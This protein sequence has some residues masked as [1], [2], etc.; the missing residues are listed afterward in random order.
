MHD[1][2]LS[3]ILYGFQ[4]AL[5]PENLIYC[6]IGATLGTLIGVLPGLGPITT[7][8]MLM[9]LT[10]K[11][12]VLASLVMLTGIYYGAHHSGS[13]AAIMLNM[14]GEPS[15]IVICLDGH[16]MARQ[17][18]AGAALGIAA[19]GSF[20]AG[21]VG[22]IVIALLSPPL[23]RVS[24]LFGPAEYASMMVMA[25]VT[26][27]ALAA[28]SL[29]TTVAMAVLGVLLGTVGT[30]IT[31]GIERNTFDLDNI[32]DGVSFIAVAVGLFAYSDIIIHLGLP[33]HARRISSK[34][35]R[36]LPTAV[37]MR[38]A[39]KPILRGTAVGASFGVL[40]GTGPLVSSFAS[41]ALEKN[42]ADDKSRFGQGAIE[43]VAGPESANNAATMTHF[44]P[45]LSLGIPAGAANA[46]L[47]G[48]I[49]IHGVTPGP[50]LMTTHPDLFWGVVA[51]MWI[52]NGMLLV[53]NLPMIG[54]WVRALMIPYRILYPAILVFCSIGVYSFNDSYGDVVLAAGFG[55]LGVIFRKLR[56]DPSPLV[57]GLVL[58]PQL[59][60]TFRR[61]LLISDGNPIVFITHPV[62]LA[63]LLLA[64]LMAVIFTSR[65]DKAVVKEV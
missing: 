4:V 37:D 43:G 28:S 15:S 22:V 55:V 31:T 61:A 50:D 63:M 5:T 44:I 25:L 52:G 30:D 6:G 12:P 33:E 59:E 49:I 13:T 53:L 60:E 35:T 7:I 58:G 3:H 29:L 21:C 64:V 47:L 11:I 17:G 23:V 34:I 16:P 41:Y 2:L 65:R 36:V 51:S 56:C 40:P 57:L 10:F 42:L 62:S 39:W 38:A 26:A 27:S 32:A 54:I 46:L 19:I 18:R 24:L 8:V 9:P 45:M 48:A 20:F 14:P 1:D